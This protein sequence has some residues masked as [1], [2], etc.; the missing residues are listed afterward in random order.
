MNDIY[1]IDPTAPSDL[2]DFAELMRVFDT[3]QGRFIADFPMEW[4]RYAHAHMSSLTNIEQMRALELWLKVGRNAVLPTDA[5]FARTRS[6][7]ENAAALV[8]QVKK[9]IGARGCPATVQPLDE[10][11][12]DPEGFPDARGG[13]IPRTAA[14]YAYAA[15]PL[16]QTSPKVVLIDPYFALQFFH[17]QSN[18]LRPSGRHRSSLSALLKE[19]VRWNRVETFRLM[20]SAEKALIY[21]EDGDTFS[22]DLTQLL[23]EV[24]S[25]GRIEIEWNILDKSVSTE[26]HP[27]YLLGMFSGLHFDWGFDTDDE[28]TTNHV[29]WMGKSELDP[30]LRNFT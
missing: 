21:D 15:R 24:D 11:L 10:V 29:H 25:L 3:G 16:L 6:W 17:R 27:R 13:H 7:P 12:L 23:R 1:G 20:V 19:A 30:L 22:S 9:V 18:Q 14:A 5:Q 8:G 28:K 26:R 4:F 2:R